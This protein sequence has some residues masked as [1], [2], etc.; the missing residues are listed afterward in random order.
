MFEM[1]YKFCKHLLRKLINGL[2]HTLYF[3]D[4]NVFFR[5]NYTNI[6]P[7]IMQFYDVSEGKEVSLVKSG[8]IG[9]SQR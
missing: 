3:S 6:F 1:L 5:V 9:F 2:I 8:T 4:N 7:P